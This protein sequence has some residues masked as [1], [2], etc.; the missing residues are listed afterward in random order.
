MLQ[1][2][3]CS[4]MLTHETES[5]VAAA[6]EGAPKVALTQ[7]T[8]QLSSIEFDSCAV[9]EESLIASSPMPFETLTEHVDITIVESIRKNCAFQR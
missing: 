4:V 5:L 2:H 1:T 6:Q 9:Q 3:C 7:E 8:S